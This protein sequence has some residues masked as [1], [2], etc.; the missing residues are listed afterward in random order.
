[1]G[2]FLFWFV[3]FIVVG[4][5][6]LH[7]NMYIPWVINWLG[8]LPGDMIVKTKKAIIYFPLGSAALTSLA[9]TLILSILSKK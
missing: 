7:Y 9:V 6:I 3:V 4:G 8:N 5:L 2:R 1:M